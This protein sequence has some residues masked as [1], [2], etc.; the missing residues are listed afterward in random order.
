[1]MHAPPVC[2]GLRDLSLPTRLLENRCPLRRDLRFAESEIRSIPNL[3]EVASR[4]QTF[5]IRAFRK[6]ISAFVP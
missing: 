1:M 2:D 5:G 6:P 4:V 3:V